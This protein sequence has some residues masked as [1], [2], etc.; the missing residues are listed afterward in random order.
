LNVYDLNPVNTFLNP[1]GF[2][3][4]HS[5]VEIDGWE[6]SFASRG[7]GIFK[8]EPK[9]AKGVK[10]YQQIEIGVLQDVEE[11]SKVIEAIE[12]LRDKFQ[13][14]HY[15]LVEKNCNHFCE[16][17]LRELLGKPLPSHVNRMSDLWTAGNMA[18]LVP[19]KLRTKAPVG[20][21]NLKAY[22]GI[23]PFLGS[24][25][26]VSATVVAEWIGAETSILSGMVNTSKGLS[27]LLED[28]L[29]VEEQK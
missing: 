3:L 1:I 13:P 16:A 10:F 2:G 14:E 24:I 17:F 8:I 19:R 25:V 29:Y 9:K 6:Y 12:R 7:G 26:E 20:D 21:R 27:I 23:L 15:D 4:H 28:Q 22:S 11:G 5:G 18:W